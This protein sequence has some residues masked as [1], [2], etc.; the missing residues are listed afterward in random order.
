MCVC[1]RARV[2]VRACVM[3]VCVSGSSSE[4]RRE[5]AER[6]HVKLTP[7]FRKLTSALRTPGAEL[8]LPSGAAQ[9]GT[10]VAAR[11]LWVG[12]QGGEEDAQQKQ[13]SWYYFLEWLKPFRPKRARGKL[14]ARRKE[15]GEIQEGFLAIDPG[16]T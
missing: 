11:M 4:K 5:K 9:S 13:C 16:G 3:C 15:E 2:C 14:C 1:A 8:A 7:P 6:P 10:G 12:S